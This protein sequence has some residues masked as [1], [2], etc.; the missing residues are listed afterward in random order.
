MGK[1]SN[2]GKL[3][4]TLSLSLKLVAFALGRISILLLTVFG[5]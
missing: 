4:V 1:L 3:G 5:F 2:E